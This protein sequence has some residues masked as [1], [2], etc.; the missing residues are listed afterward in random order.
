[1][2]ELIIVCG[3][4]GSGKTTFAK[5]YAKK[6]NYEYIDF[7]KE[8]HLKIQKEHSPYNPY[9]VE[10][11][12]GQFIE[13][14][15]NLLNSNPSKNYILDGFFKWHKDWWEEED[16]NTLSTLNKFLKYHSIRI[17][18]IFVPFKETYARYLKMHGNNV[19]YKATMKERQRS[20]LKRIAESKWVT[21]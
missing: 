6:F 18:Y 7:D 20:L 12:I 15:T 4:M 17:I 21:Q 3:L 19:E 2:P 13:T 9:I 1:M 11:Q 10:Q 8:Y 14:I 16:Y 5:E